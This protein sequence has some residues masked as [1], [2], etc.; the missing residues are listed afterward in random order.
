MK[1]K[2]NKAFT[3]TELVIVIAVVAIL[4]AVLIPT[5]S[6]VIEKA[7]QSNDTVLVKNLNT[8]LSSYEALSGKPST[9]HEALTAVAEEGFLVEKLTP[10]SS[11]EILWEQTSNRFVLVKD[12]A[13]VFGDAST[14]APLG[15]TY[16]AITDDLTKLSD[17][18]RSYYFTADTVLSGTT[19]E[20]STSADFSALKDQTIYL[21]VKEGIADTTLTIAM[22][23]KLGVVGIPSSTAT[24][25]LYGT[26]GSVGG[27]I[28]ST[29][30]TGFSAAAVVGMNSL[31][32]FGNVTKVYLKSGKVVAET[33]SEINTVN[34]MMIT[35][36]QI[37]IQIEPNGKVLNVGTAN[38]TL[39][40]KLDGIITGDKSN[41]I[42]S[43]STISY[44]FAGGIGTEESPY[45]ITNETQLK[46]IATRIDTF[47]D[48]GEN[49]YYFK[50]VNDIR[51]TKVIKLS[52]VG[53]H[54]D[55]NG[56]TITYS[57]TV[58]GTNISAGEIDLT[59]GAKLIIDGDGYID[60]DDD[61]L[62]EES[63]GQMF[64]IN[65]VSSLQIKSGHFYAGL[66]CVLADGN[67]VCEIYGGHFSAS[68]TYSGGY[69]LLNLQDDSSAQIK[70]YG[71]T[72]VNY[73]PSS[74]ATENPIANFVADGYV[75]VREDGN[76]MDEF[77]CTVQPNA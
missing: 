18:T 71:G 14:T 75:S 32:V 42:V 30:A 51:L 67:S 39:I 41:T 49:I 12:N 74:S 5:F 57:G 77:T 68:A 47:N 8:A 16:W 34:V 19:V 33:G 66:T 35:D 37:G 15:K 38:S 26:I 44:N 21:Q 27:A 54:L 23:S 70:V 69:W 4:A 63:S 50:L 61:Y 6:N 53:R 48:M 52:N 43:E 25:N 9:M 2:N 58:S 11:G 46:N 45:L 36:G 7:N 55:L 62:N 3:I 10:R 17:A 72:F 73:D 31:H 60:F 59:A 29:N 40:N 76:T 13:I 20:T 56:H 28:N 65:G 64:Y 22:D 1:R 24:I